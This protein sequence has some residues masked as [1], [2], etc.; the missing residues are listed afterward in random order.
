MRKSEIFHTL[1]DEVSKVCEVRKDCIIQGSKLQAVVDARTLAVQYL[2]RIGLSSDDI[3]LLVLRE[4]AGDPELCPS[5]P[6]LKKKAN[7]INK[8]FN[9]Y[10]SRCLESYAFCLMSQDIKDF[11]RRKYEELYLSG[12]KALPRE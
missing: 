7:G 9:S 3:A 1:L 10:S 6:D 5:L 12:M 11:C 4:K 8:T 2:R